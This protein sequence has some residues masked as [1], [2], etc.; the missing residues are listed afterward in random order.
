[1]TRRVIQ[2]G[3]THTHTHTHSFFSQLCQQVNV[4]L[5]CLSL[6]LRQLLVQNHAGGFQLTNFMDQTSHHLQEEQPSDERLQTAGAAWTSLVPTHTPGPCTDP[7]PLCRSSSPAGCEPVSGRP[8]WPADLHPTPEH[9]PPFLPSPL[10]S[11]GI[12]TGICQTSVSCTFW[13][14]S[15]THASSS[16]TFLSCHSSSLRACS[17][18]WRRLRRA[19]SVALC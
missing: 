3:H 6:C 7:L 9:Q 10:L 1:M 12:I 11:A 8:S 16:P 17:S 2:G 5:L 18:W 13:P 19:N 15:H 4:W 14:G